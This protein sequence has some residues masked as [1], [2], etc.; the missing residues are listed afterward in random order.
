MKSIYVRVTPLSEDEVSSL[1]RQAGGFE[2]SQPIII[3]RDSLGMLVCIK[4]ED[5][6]N[7]S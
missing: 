7:R 3:A 4:P 5:V 6:F 2:F 1:K